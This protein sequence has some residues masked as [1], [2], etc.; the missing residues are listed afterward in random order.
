MHWYSLSKQNESQTM[1]P[2][3]VLSRHSLSRYGVNLNDCGEGTGPIWLDNAECH[4]GEANLNEC[5]H[6][7]IGSHN[8]GHD[9]D[10]ACRCCD[11]NS[12]CDNLGC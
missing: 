3:H 5:S 12:W 8:C 11:N 10:A 1:Q 4:G 6:N 9:E 7:P 2:P